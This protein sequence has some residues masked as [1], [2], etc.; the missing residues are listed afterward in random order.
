MS[1]HEPRE[2]LE[3]QIQRKF[4]TV[5]TDALIRRIQHAADFG[6]DD[7]QYELNRRLKLEGKT[8]RWDGDRVEVIDLPLSDEER[9]K[10]AIAEAGEDGT[11]DHTTARIIASRYHDGQAS[12][13]YSLASSGRVDLRAL[14]PELDA[15]VFEFVDDGEALDELNALLKYIVESGERDAIPYWHEATRWGS[16]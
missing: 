3:V 4:K 1:E 11:I 6:Y 8:W 12:A 13:L 5:T 7:E 14:G 9:I 2:P 16:E 15:N 10:L